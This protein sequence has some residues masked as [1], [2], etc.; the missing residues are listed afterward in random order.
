MNI[1]PKTPITQLRI[2]SGVPFDRNYTNTR[3][4]TSGVLQQSE[5]ESK[6][7]FTYNESGI[8]KIQNQ[9][10]VD[11]PIDT[12]YNCN[13]IMFRNRGLVDNP[14]WIYAFI[15]K[16]EYVSPESTNISFE[17]DYMQT[18]MTNWIINPCFVEREHSTIDTIGYNTVDE[19]LELGDIVFDEFSYTGYIN[20]A[21]RNCIVIASTV[22]SDNNPVTGASY[23]HVYSGVT[24]YRFDTAPE[25]NAFL[26]SISPDSRANAI[27]SIFMMPRIFWGDTGL[28]AIIQHFNKAKNIESLGNYTPRNKKLLTHPYNYLLVTNQQGNNVEYKYERFG[29][30][31]CTF[32]I[33]GDMSCNPK[34]ILVPQN[35][36]GIN[37]YTE[38][39]IL[40]GFPQCTYNIDTFK[41]WLAQS[42]SSTALSTALAAGQIVGGVATANPALVGTGALTIGNTLAKI[43]D[44]SV[45]SNT[46]KGSSTSN[47]LFAMDAFDFMFL[48]AHITEEYAAI[49][50]GYFDINGYATHRVKI[51]NLNSRP[52]WNYVK[53]K[54][55]NVTGAISFDDLSKINDVFNRG[56]TF[57]HGDY[58]GDYSRNNAPITEDGENE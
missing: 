7:K 14:K 18:W 16:L 29:G 58:V 53:T 17:L 15:T 30:T 9:L 57:W 36:K 33:G 39:L 10:R 55:S 40:D 49:I 22:D 21:T 28:P 31:A 24:Y 46:A 2:L 34:V 11:Q 20:G 51:P 27:V 13:Y 5:M 42:A 38:T 3:Y 26:D 8:I 12:L 48:P 19:N 54:N 25:A 43:A 47:I 45:Q 56:I 23:S 32:V 44:H 37:N 35:Y 41:A 52:S 1:E 4:F 6:A 50:D